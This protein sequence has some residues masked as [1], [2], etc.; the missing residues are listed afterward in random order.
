MLPA[1]NAVILIDEADGLLGARC[2]QDNRHDRNLVNLLL[3][4]V[5]R[6]PGLVI[7]RH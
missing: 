4:L 3:D 1:E 2:Q 6:Y 5:E 7:T